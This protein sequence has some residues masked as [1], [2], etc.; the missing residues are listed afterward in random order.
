VGFVSL[1]S[2]IVELVIVYG[3]PWKLITACRAIVL[4]GTGPTSVNIIYEDLRPPIK[5]FL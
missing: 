2:S 4:N 1:D 3:A 5:G